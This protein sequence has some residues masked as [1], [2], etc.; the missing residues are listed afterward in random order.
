M[1]INLIEVPS[2]MCSEFT[3]CA[4]F[5]KE[6]LKEK[7]TVRVS[8]SYDTKTRISTS[9]QVGMSRVGINFKADG[10]KTFESIENN[11]ISGGVNVL[12]YFVKSKKQDAEA[13][14]EYVKAVVTDAVKNYLDVELD[15]L[16]IELELDRFNR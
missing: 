8:M 14:K 12:N 7:K 2:P 6:M 9:M 5:N 13:Y 10:F 16:T 3:M 1:K 11:F 15:E 4:D